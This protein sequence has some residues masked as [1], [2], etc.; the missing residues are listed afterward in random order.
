M[1]NLKL[2]PPK[3][4]LT[5]LI[6]E[7]LHS[8][9][10]HVGVQGT[11]DLVQ[12]EIWIRQGRQTVKRIV[13]KCIVCK[14]NIRKAFKYPGPHPYLWREL[15]IPDRSRILEL[16]LQVHSNSRMHLEILPNIMSVYSHV[17]PQGQYFYSSLIVFP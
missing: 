5:R 6:I 13:N 3:S 2:L 4:P 1:N 14:Y 16:T 15:T 12:K 11:L 8:V 7:N 9:H 10:H 17:L